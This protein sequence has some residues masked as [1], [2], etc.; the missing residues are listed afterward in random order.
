MLGEL[1]AALVLETHFPREDVS[2]ASEGW[3]GDTFA[4]YEKEG[5]APLVVWATEWDTEKD[6]IE[7]QAQAFKIA[8]KLTPTDQ[9]V[10][11]PAVRKKTSV[12]FVL[13]V[14]KGTQDDLMENVWK[15]K[16]TKDKATDPYGE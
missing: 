8:L 15:S 9:N 6:A 3:A 5:A 2:A 10:M 11:S 13:N 16:R 1:G 7:F 14:P 12:A 4:V